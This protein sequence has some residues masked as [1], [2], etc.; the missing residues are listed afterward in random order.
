M[1]FL[2]EEVHIHDPLVN[3]LNWK[4]VIISISHNGMRA[5]L[6]VRGR[7]IAAKPELSQ[8]ASQQASKPASQQASKPASQ[9]ASK[10]ASQPASQPQQASQQASKP[11]SQQASK[12]ASQQASQQASK[13]NRGV[14][15]CQ[16]TILFAAFLLPPR[17][18]WCWPL[19]PPP[20]PRYNAL[21][22][23]LLPRPTRSKV[24]YLFLLRSAE[25]A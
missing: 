19:P 18:C 21:Y 11:A 1:P 5:F 9:Q 3:F 24:D 16:C 8:P 6:F 20:P 10:P 2:Q 13:T 14:R 4:E 25:L 23:S 7:K 17:P 12:Q 22:M 15:N